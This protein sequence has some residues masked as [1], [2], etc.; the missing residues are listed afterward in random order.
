MKDLCKW[1]DEDS[2]LES[3]GGTS[4]GTLS[5]DIGPWSDPQA[6]HTI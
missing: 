3:L 5:E 2:I 1:I 6:R 4:K